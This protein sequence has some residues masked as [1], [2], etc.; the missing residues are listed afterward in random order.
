[1][2]KDVLK[3][4]LQAAHDDLERVKSELD[5]ACV[6]AKWCSERM[7]EAESTRDAARKE[8]TALRVERETAYGDLAEARRERDELRDAHEALCNA[9]LNTAGVDRDESMRLSRQAAEAVGSLVAQRNKASDDAADWMTRWAEAGQ[10]VMD[11]EAERDALRAELDALKAAPAQTGWI[12]VGDWAWAHPDGRIVRFDGD[13][14]GAEDATRF[15]RGSTAIEAAA[16]AG[17]HDFPGLTD[18][19]AGDP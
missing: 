19:S 15:Y 18:H 5:E 9:I 10:S 8:V 12:R 7:V 13:F 3:W 16:A 17:W 6:R 4:C 11:A 14:W 2:R 1:M